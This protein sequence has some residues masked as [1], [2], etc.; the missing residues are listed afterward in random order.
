[1]PLLLPALYSSASAVGESTESAAKG[2][3]NALGRVSTRTGFRTR[4]M[5]THLDVAFG[6]LRRAGGA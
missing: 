3:D 6:G 5:Q 2:L 1:M 4:N